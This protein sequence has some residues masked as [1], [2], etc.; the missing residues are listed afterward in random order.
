[1]EASEREQPLRARERPL[2][3]TGSVEKKDC[4]GPE[5]TD[6]G[7]EKSNP[8]EQNGETLSASRCG[9]LYRAANMTLHFCLSVL[10][11]RG[12]LLV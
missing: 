7:G 11:G 9:A 3:E 12:I 8:G 4:G 2:R 6:P 1:M 5:S 10:H